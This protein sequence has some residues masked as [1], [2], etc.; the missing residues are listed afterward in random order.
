L[1]ADADYYIDKLA[2]QSHIEGGFFSEV[3]RAE[4]KISADDLPIRFE[5]SRCFSTSIYFLLKKGYHSKFH[6]LKSDELWHFYDGAA[7]TIFLISPEGNVSELKLGKNLESGEKF[8][9]V[10]PHGYWIGAKVTGEGDFTLIGC[11]V[12]PGFEFQD[13]ILGDKEKL[14]MQF[15]K[16]ENIICELT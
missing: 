3:Y 5:N 1:I 14:L 4:E 8:Q 9:I 6:I 11:T 2:L 12:S 15:P 7:I 10:I 13:F 16:L